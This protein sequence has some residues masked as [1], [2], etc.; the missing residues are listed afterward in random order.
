MGKHAHSIDTQVIDRIQTAAGGRVF[1]PRDFL[2]L[3]SRYAVDQALSR[4]CRAGR[5]RK[6]TR[7]LYDVPRTDPQL[8]RLSASTDAI[9]DALR[10]RDA[11]RLQPTGAYAANMLG[12]SDQV[13]MKIVYLTDG[14]SRRV[15]I[16]NREIV[17]KRTTPRNMAT[18]GRLSGLVIQT[19]RWLGQK[20]VDD[21]VIA[22]L[23][24]NLKPADRAGLL[25]DVQFAP[26][27]IAT[28]FRRLAEENE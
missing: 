15:T 19:L 3:G 7:G 6:V 9:A 13:P 21:T 22:K 24:R 27:W 23:R 4:N 28:I 18:A 10:G 5:L 8:G 12:L 2:D 1:T 16:D 14:R 17:L 25:A 26:A 11:I 20:N